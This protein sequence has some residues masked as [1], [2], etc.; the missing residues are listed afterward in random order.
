MARQIVVVLFV[1]QRDEGV[2]RS[3]VGPTRHDPGTDARTDRHQTDAQR[4]MTPAQ[5]DRVL[6][7]HAEIVFARTSPQQKLIIV[8]YTH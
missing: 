1:A 8:D 2:C 5:I 7:E 4:D 6:S 3:R